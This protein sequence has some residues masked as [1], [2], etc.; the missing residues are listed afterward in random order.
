M[1][2]KFTKFI[3]ADVKTSS[4]EWSKPQLIWGRELELYSILA[5]KALLC[6]ATY[7]GPSDLRSEDVSAPSPL[8]SYEPSAGAMV[9]NGS[10]VNASSIKV[11][12]P[13]GGIRASGF[14]R[15]LDDPIPLALTLMF[16]HLSCHYNHQNH[17]FSRTPE[18]LKMW[19]QKGQNGTSCSAC[20]IHNGHQSTYT[21]SL[22][23]YLNVFTFDYDHHTVKM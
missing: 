3:Q 20:S 22:H 1:W 11:N 10:M 16:R 23:S 9:A 6:Q 7:L 17:S 15:S 2:W 8:P 18:P 14:P 19:S 4:L 5:F 13:G 12:I 21:H